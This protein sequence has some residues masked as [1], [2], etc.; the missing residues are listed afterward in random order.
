MSG[1]VKYT[2]YEHTDGII[3]VENKETN[4]ESDKNTNKNTNIDKNTNTNNKVN[5][6]NITN[7]ELS[8]IDVSNII[9]NY[10]C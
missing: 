5:T 4:N 1:V 8:S 7:K 3:V 10:G 6:T 2:I 9:Y